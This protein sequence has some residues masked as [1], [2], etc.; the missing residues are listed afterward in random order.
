MNIA[1]RMRALLE[2]MD[3]GASGDPKV[4]VPQ[5]VLAMD[6]VGMDP[7]DEGHQEIFFAML[8]KLATNKSAL[9]KAMKNYNAS[10][11][12]KALKVAKMGV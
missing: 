7:G 10:R 1:D 11:A 5:L 2:E 9:L 6:A 8:K 3:E 12:A 4:L